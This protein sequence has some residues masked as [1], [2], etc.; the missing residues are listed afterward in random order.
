M[1]CEGENCYDKA[2]ERHHKFSQ[3]KLNKKL[4]AD[5]IHHSDNIMFLCYNCHHNKPVFKWT[6]IQFCNHFGI[7]PRTKTG[8]D[9]AKKMFDNT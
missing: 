4:Y 2:T 5:Y 3:T 6:E 7:E 1:M 9:L 8:K